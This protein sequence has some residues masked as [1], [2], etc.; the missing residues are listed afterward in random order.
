VEWLRSQL[1][2]SRLMML[3]RMYRE[4]TPDQYHKLQEISDRMSRD[5]GRGAG[6]GH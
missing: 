2:E 6:G 3:Y 1:N 4:L 5:R